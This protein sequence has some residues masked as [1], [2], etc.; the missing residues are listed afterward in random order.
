M[1]GVSSLNALTGALAITSKNAYISV[2]ASTSNV[3]LQYNN[4]ALNGLT[5]GGSNFTTGI[6]GLAGSNGITLTP[7][8]FN[9]VI[10]ISG[11]GSSSGSS[12]T[13]GT[14]PTDGSVSVSGVGSISMTT[15]NQG[16]INVGDTS[17][18][19]ARQTF[20]N[21]GPS[22]TIKMLNGANQ[23]SANMTFFNDQ[24]NTSW[25]NL[26][27]SPVAGYFPNI[28]TPAV[29]LVVQGGGQNLSAYADFGAGRHLVLGSGPRG[30][31]PANGATIPY[32][33]A[34][35]SGAGATNAV[36]MTVSAGGVGVDGNATSIDLVADTITHNGVPFTG[37]GGSISAGGASVVCDDPVA[38]G[39]ITLTTTGTGSSGNITIDTT[40]GSSG[41]LALK[42]VS[43]ITLDTSTGSGGVQITT[44]TTASLFE[45][46][47][48]AGSAGQIQFQ[49]TD[50]TNPAT[51][52]IGGTSNATGLYVSNT[53]LLFNG[54]AV[55][56]VGGGTTV[57]VVW[58][59]SDP[60][61]V[62]AVVNVGTLDNPTGTFICILAVS[63]PASPAVNPAPVD[64]PA[65]WT[66][67]APL[68]TA[69]I[70][71]MYY[72][73]HSFDWDTTTTY[74]QGHIVADSNVVY[75]SATNSNINLV[76]KTNTGSWQAIGSTVP[77]GGITSIYATGDTPTDATSI[78]FISGSGISIANTSN[79]MTFTASTTGSG[80][81]G[82]VSGTGVNKTFEYVASNVYATRQGVAS[83]NGGLYGSTLEAT[84]IPPYGDASSTLTWA[85]LAPSIGVDT[86]AGGALSNVIPKPSGASNAYC[87]VLKPVADSNSNAPITITDEGS[88]VIGFT[89]TAGSLIQDL[90]EVNM[91]PEANIWK[92]HQNGNSNVIVATGATTTGV[93][94][95][96]LGSTI[97]V[98]GINIGVSANGSSNLP[99]ILTIPGVDGASYI[100]FPANAGEPP[101]NGA[102]NG[103]LSFN[104]DGA[105]DT[106]TYLGAT[107]VAGY[108]NQVE[109][110]C[111]QAGG[112]SNSNVNLF[113]DFGVGS[114][115]VLGNSTTQT[116]P[117]GGDL[118][119]I[120]MS[121]TA[122]N[123]TLTIN[124]GGQ[125][126]ST[127]TT[128]NLIC[129]FLTLNGVRIPQ[130][131][132]VYNV[133]SNISDN[134]LPSPAVMPM[135]VVSILS[136]YPSNE[137]SLSGN[138][139][140][141]FTLYAPAGTSNHPVWN[142]V[143]LFDNSD[144]T[145]SSNTI[146]SPVAVGPYT[147]GDGSSS[148]TYTTPTINVS[149]TTTNYN[150]TS[151]QQYFVYF[152][153]SNDGPGWLSSNTSATV[154]TGSTF[155][156]TPT[157]PT[158][159]VWS[160]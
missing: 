25:T 14:A 101:T 85:G 107:N 157:P 23:L 58:N 73:Q 63:A 128:T 26:N 69:G 70:A 155:T 46:T 110:L 17:A 27:T 50:A 75:V 36:K 35:Q 38:S 16:T 84:G 81:Y 19:P 104:T 125:S 55:G 150:A 139:T 137:V 52:T 57:P 32:L 100:S 146:S 123:T 48:G 67:V 121:N 30:L 64:T 40:A 154:D 148:N 109:M 120:T 91:P 90:A 143:Q 142:S 94:N 33:T 111:V 53:Q 129:D 140:G 8:T 144:G 80:L 4:I 44:S 31:V 56:G 47:G 88:G 29:P 39:S 13:N 152:G 21:V 41:V 71:N 117:S 108:S 59:D 116:A 3:S 122:S 127:S 66:P 82:E 77:G 62:G 112:A 132:I 87:Y 76:P 61:A 130:P 78:E 74:E 86:L 138:L 22:S 12:I 20:M 118:P 54:V 45:D 65:N 79:T 9:N 113:T 6:V 99:G 42:A 103:F 134:S 37:G 93:I 135:E 149:F 24:S 131:P 7:D 145:N 160:P 124:A 136:P 98:S 96:D 151:S 153:G 92:F 10:T 106:A 5:A 60:Y 102:S 83:Y 89:S 34:S 2:G 49:S 126:L 97:N 51:L 119:N 15:A 68:Q 43:G 156:F 18:N 159:Y 105:Q 115:Y 158:P 28:G 72:D 147:F 1:S 141:T 133:L 11:G 114:L 95:F